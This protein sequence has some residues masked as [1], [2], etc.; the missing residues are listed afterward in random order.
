M[1]IATLAAHGL[2][3]VIDAEATLQMGVGSGVVHTGEVYDSNRSLFIP[4]MEACEIVREDV[5]QQAISVRDEDRGA[6]I[7]LRPDGFQR[8]PTR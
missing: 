5:K 7:I 6:K 4:W 1:D 3:P 8:I 2:Y